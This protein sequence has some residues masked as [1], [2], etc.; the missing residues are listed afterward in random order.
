[1]RSCRRTT[2]SRFASLNVTTGSFGQSTCFFRGGAA[3]AL[4]VGAAAAAFGA[5][6]AL[7]GGLT[8]DGALCEELAGSFFEGGPSHPGPEARV[9][10]IEAAASIEIESESARI[11]DTLAT[12]A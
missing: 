1:L 11:R 2:V 6:V 8:V 7:G 12:M 5:G 10:P 9:A 4:S 3:A